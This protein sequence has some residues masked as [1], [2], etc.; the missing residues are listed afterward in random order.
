MV[1][2]PARRPTLRSQIVQPTHRC[3]T[4]TH[5]IAT[6]LIGCNAVNFLTNVK[7]VRTKPPRLTNRR[8]LEVWTEQRSLAESITFVGQAAYTA[9]RPCSSTAH[10]KP[11]NITQS[12]AEIRPAYLSAQ[13]HRQDIGVLVR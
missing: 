9:F 13:M 8:L 5:T 6:R 10:I 11:L 2:R 3:Q 4:I 1:L 12:A 7:L